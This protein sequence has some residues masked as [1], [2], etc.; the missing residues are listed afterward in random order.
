[1]EKTSMPIGGAEP[2]TF[3]LQGKCSTDELNGLRFLQ[4]LIFQKTTAH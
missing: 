1:M 4:L 2:P 3:C